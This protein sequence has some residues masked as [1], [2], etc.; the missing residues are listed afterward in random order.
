M[1]CTQDNHSLYTAALRELSRVLKEPRGRF[2]K[3][4]GHVRNFTVQELECKLSIYWTYFAF[5]GSGLAG[6]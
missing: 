1:E 2:L 6:C 3:A 4:G 5:E